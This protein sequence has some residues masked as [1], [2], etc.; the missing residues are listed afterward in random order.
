MA[1]EEDEIV[2][3]IRPGDYIEELEVQVKAITEDILRKGV[4]RVNRKY[5][6][7]EIPEFGNDKKSRL[8]WEME[9]IR[10]CREGYDG[11]PGKYYY[12]FNHCRIKHKSRG[13]IKPDFRT[14]DLE[15]FKFLEKVQATPGKGIVCIKRRQVG[16]SWKSAADAVHDCQFSKNFDI[17]MN[18]K[19]ILDS[20]GLLNK[21]RTVYR[22][23][24]DFLRVATS[25]D[26][27]DAML[28]ATYEK[29]KFGNQGKLKSGTESSILVVAP[30]A[31]GHAGNQYLKLVH[32]EA[33]ETEELEAIAANAEDCI[34][35]DGIRVGTWI[36]FG[37]MGNSDKAGRGLMEFWKNHKMYDLERFPFWGYNELI[38]DE[39]GN[40]NIIESVRWILYNRKKKEK[41]SAKV[42]NKFI[43]KYPLNEED[44]FLS[45]MACG[46]G[47]PLIINKQINYLSDNPPDARVGRMKLVGDKPEFE[48]NPSGH[49]TM[50]ELPE[51]IKNGYTA[52]LDPAEDDDVDK[53]KD[54]SDLGFSIM[55]R[56]FGL[57]PARAVFEYCHR[58]A[59]L[60][61]AY[62]QMAL[63][64]IMYG[65][66]IHIE[67]NKG[68]WRAYDWFSLYYPDLLTLP[69]TT[70][71]S[72]RNG[73]E[74]K[75]G[76]KMTK[77]RKLQM[78][79]LLNQYLDNYC[80]PNE[81]IGWK[82]V[83]S[84]KFLEQCKVFGGKG[85]D[86]DLG[87]SY[88]WNLIIQQSDKKVAQRESDAPPPQT[89]HYERTMNGGI[90]LITSNKPLN[91]R[92]IPKSI[93]G[94]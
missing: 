84:K 12:Y 1:K 8:N 88:G 82:G 89:H 91:T 5:K 81:A 92:V 30:T 72:L 39:F 45:T 93:F 77:D 83:Q 33:G 66:K 32:D 62:K 85:K 19:G 10:R 38:M 74:L 44:A 60:E 63:A 15:W 64:L 16:M 29:D 59:K 3:I 40:D 27:R 67:L 11:L 20:Q 87:V 94:R 36:I 69:P 18:S 6:H 21:V 90:K 13:K 58:P 4:P 2:A 70:A 48:P 37:T 17:G 75:H 55:A 41:G 49:C 80:L 43:Q 86:D 23:Q 52:T 35:Q 24:T 78:E 34:M 56:P 31:T 79:G 22:N 73:V 57:L 68:G 28:F 25:T 7:I 54:S 26:R 42:Y 47:N 9:E 53:T 14:M 51:K 61:D 50:Y 65:A 46:V 76:V 71:N